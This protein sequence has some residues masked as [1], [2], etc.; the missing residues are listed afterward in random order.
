MGPAVT[1]P[2]VARHIGRDD[3]APQ[4]LAVKCLPVLGERQLLGAE[5]S[6]EL[7]RSQVVVAAEGRGTNTQLPL[8][9]AS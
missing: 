5:I 4:Q 7:P 8:G 1:H 6:K 2:G 9:V 3:R